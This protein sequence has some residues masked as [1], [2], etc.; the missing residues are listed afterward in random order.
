MFQ[1]ILTPRTSLA[2]SVPVLCNFA[3]VDTPTQYVTGSSPQVETPDWSMYEL[4]ISAA[5]D[6]IES[7]ADCLPERAD[8]RELRLFPRSARPSECLQ[9]LLP[10]SE[11][12]HFHHAVLVVWLASHGQH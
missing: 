6:E 1:Q 11:L 3:R 2:V 4:F 9:L 8:F 5:T 10:C 7:M 12:Q